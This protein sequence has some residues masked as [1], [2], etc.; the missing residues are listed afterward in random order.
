MRYTYHITQPA[1]NPPFKAE[2]QNP[3]GKI[4]YVI[5][6]PEIFRQNKMTATNDIAGLEK[7]LKQ[8]HVL[9]ANDKL[10]DMSGQTT[11]DTITGEIFLNPY[12]KRL[13]AKKME[14]G[15]NAGYE[16]L[17]EY[18]ELQ[19]RYENTLAELNATDKR[20]YKFGLLQK[21]LEKIQTEKKRI[22]LGGA[23]TNY[24][25]GP[26]SRAGKQTYHLK[27]L[28]FDK[29]GKFT[30]ED[31]QKM[32][33]LYEP[34]FEILESGYPDSEVN[35]PAGE[36]DYFITHEVLPDIVSDIQTKPGEYQKYVEH[37]KNYGKAR[38]FEL[39]TYDIMTIEPD[40]VTFQATD[41]L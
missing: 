11:G 36:K 23:Y 30:G 4:V 20:S 37:F 2:V 26:D 7:H 15:G 19:T 6:G 16:Q 27:N 24:Q 3:F 17:P 32:L 31:I 29:G 40:K 12:H 41:F 5:E 28:K 13:F 18:Q 10:I 39:L 21:K 9:D 8:I 22:A 1:S 14:T 38:G 33:E 34:P 35:R 25:A